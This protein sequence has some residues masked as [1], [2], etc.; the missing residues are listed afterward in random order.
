MYKSTIDASH[1]H[2]VGTGR[3]VVNVVDVVLRAVSSSMLCYENC[4]TSLCSPR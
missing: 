4:Q 2:G 1:A 3:G